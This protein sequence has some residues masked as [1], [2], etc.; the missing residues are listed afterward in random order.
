[1]LVLRATAPPAL[2][3]PQFKL[4]FL[5]QLSVSPPPPPITT[6]STEP[7][8]LEPMDP[9]ETI[10]FNDD[11]GYG[12]GEELLDELLADESVADA[13]GGE[14]AADTINGDESTNPTAGGTVASHPADDAIEAALVDVQLHPSLAGKTVREK[15]N[16]YKRNETKDNPRPPDSYFI[17]QEKEFPEFDF[18]N[19]QGGG[20]EEDEEEESSSSSQSRTQ[21]SKGN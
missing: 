12:D 8:V 6:M 10:N 20:Y 16:F 3:L 17:Q 1:M 2:M 7:D 11:D 5:T 21:H 4:R 14:P 13:T 9:D 15:I 18:E 19:C